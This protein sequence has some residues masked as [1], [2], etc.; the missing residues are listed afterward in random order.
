MV[1]LIIH[2]KFAMTDQVELKQLSP[3]RPNFDR[4]PSILADS[5]A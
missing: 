1:G 5:K 4:F 2:G 3:S